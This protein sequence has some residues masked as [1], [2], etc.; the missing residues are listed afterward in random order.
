MAPHPIG[1]I[2]ERLP[3]GRLFVPTRHAHG[4]GDTGEDH[5]DWD[6]DIFLWGTEK[7][8]ESS[9]SGKPLHCGENPD[10]RV[11]TFSDPKR[12]GPAYTVELGRGVDAAIRRAGLEDVLRE[13]MARA[14]GPEHAEEDMGTGRN[15]STKQD[16]DHYISDLLWSGERETLVIEATGFEGNHNFAYKFGTRCGKVTD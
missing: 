2:H 4:S 9:V 7:M 12:Y 13:T 10:E 3:D 8:G 15:S 6:H 11:L 1:Y 14:R 5:A 16:W